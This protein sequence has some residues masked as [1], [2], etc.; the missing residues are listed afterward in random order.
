VLRPVLQA[1]I[2]YLQPRYETA[3]AQMDKIVTNSENVQRRIQKYLGKTASV[4]YPPCDTEHFVWQGQGDYYLS[5]A[6]LDPLKRV[7]SIVQ[8]FLNLPDKK[9]I[10]AS[11]GAQLGY[12]KKLAAN[13]PNIQF[14]G[15]LSEQALHSLVGNAL[16][17]LYVAKDEDFGMSPVEAMAAGKPVIGVAEGGLLE[18]ILPEQTGLLLPPDFTHQ[19]LAEA[20]L[21]LSPARALA[22][23][24]ACVLRAQA[25]NTSRFVEQMRA[26]VLRN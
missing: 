18:T 11:G 10:V 21:Q 6:R 12:L 24:E 2:D 23:R 9:L 3:V 17:V 13:A 15:W 8:A 22:M 5:T 19:H 20:V 25:F 4:V 7:E 1:F 16:A 26:F 14:T